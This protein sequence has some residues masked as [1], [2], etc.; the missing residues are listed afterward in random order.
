VHT[1][2][3]MVG[4]SKLARVGREVGAI[5]D[6]RL[7]AIVGQTGVKARM[8]PLTLELRGGDYGEEKFE[9]EIVKNAYFAPVLAG[10]VVANSLIANSGFD[11]DSTMLARGT[12]DLAEGPDL[13]F[14]MAFAGDGGANPGVAIAGRLSQLLG[15]LWINR[16]ETV[17]VKRIDVA[18]E[19]VS[20]S[21]RYRVESVIRD[22]TPLRAG[23]TLTVR[24]VLSRHKGD[25]RTHEFQF[26]VPDTLPVDQ[27]L[28][29]AVGPPTYIERA[30]GGPITELARSADDLPT[31]IDALGEIRS[32]HRLVAVLY[33]K[34]NSTVAGGKRL[35]GLPPTA[36]NLLLPKQRATPVK[37]RANPLATAEIELDGPLVGGMSVRVG[38]DSDLEPEGK[39]R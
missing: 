4:S 18:V 11:R 13:P 20:G 21:P 29:L 7:P 36:R 38:Y 34:T 1:L 12:I 14:E 19:V 31:L 9:F 3:D 25:S 10:A 39:N 30:L 16:F 33:N 24:C 17:D 5:V 26:V 2:A 28:T 22:R 35:E 15:A 37:L 27:V 23:G 6:D 8:M 32:D